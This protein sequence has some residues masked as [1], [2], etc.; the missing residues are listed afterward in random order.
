MADLSADIAAIVER[1]SP[2]VLRVEARRGRPATGVVWDTGV[3]LTADHVIEDEDNI[4]VGDQS[5]KA[6]LAGR[7]PAS[8]LALLRVE[9][10]QA[11]PAARGRLANVRIGHLVLALGNAGEPQVTLGVVSGFSGRFRS[12]RGG[13]AQSLIQTTAELLPG[14][15]GGPLVSA[16]GQVVG[17]NS[18]NFGRGISRALPADG[19]DLVVASLRQHGRIRRA[20]LGIGAQPVALPE[21]LRHQL[22]QDTGMLVVTVESQGP[23]AG[24]GVLQGDIVVSLDGRPVRQLEELFGALRGLEVGS[25]HRL[26][27]VRA[28]QLNELDVTL[29]E[30][31]S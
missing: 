3:V 29:G 21:G 13:E 6:T 2:S 8:D 9:G 22:D 30:R 5:L 7:D 11:P 16:N 24:A 4:Q 23:A 20:Y 17:I 15:S 18:W 1:L 12:W 28:G 25:S 14:F 27:V 26:R 31:A 19:V 10:L